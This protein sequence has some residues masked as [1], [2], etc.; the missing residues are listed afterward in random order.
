MLAGLSTAQ[1]P[2]TMR[3]WESNGGA[4]AVPRYAY[5][6]QSDDFAQ[7]VSGLERLKAIARTDLF[8]G[9]NGGARKP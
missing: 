1:A 8:S 7:V 9:Q 6:Q 3:Q 2:L 4:F 5:P